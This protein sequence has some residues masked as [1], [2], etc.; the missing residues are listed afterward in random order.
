MQSPT[1][2]SKELLTSSAIQIPEDGTPA[3]KTA[4]AFHAT[5]RNNFV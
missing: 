2:F 3:E 4:M 1:D 5:A